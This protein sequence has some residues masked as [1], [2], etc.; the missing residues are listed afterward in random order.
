M[1]EIHGM[2]RSICSG[3]AIERKTRTKTPGR[4]SCACWMSIAVA[5][6]VLLVALILALEPQTFQRVIHTLSNNVPRQAGYDYPSH[7]L[8]STKEYAVL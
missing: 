6:L 4:A 8:F 7:Y 1:A 3:N 2:V 5:M